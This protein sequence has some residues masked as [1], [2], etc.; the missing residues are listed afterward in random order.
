MTT[1]QSKPQ[2]SVSGT[3]TDPFG[4]GKVLGD[5]KIPGVD[6]QALLAS[7]QKNLS[8]LADANKQVVAGV[9]QI[10]QRQA[11]HI[12]QAVTEAAQAAK[13]AA[14]S[15]A[16]KE[17][18]AHSVDLTKQALDKAVEHLKEVSEIAAKAQAQAA[19]TVNK[20]VAEGLDELRALLHRK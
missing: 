16:A 11:E 5:L 13:S 1:D 14:S 7:H 18:A 8:A 9:Q 3:N 10:A 20:R 4:L 2:E 15:P 6:V 17:L 19:E 12:R